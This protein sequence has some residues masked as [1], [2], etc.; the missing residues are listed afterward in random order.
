MADVS[1][2]PFVRKCT[3]RFMSWLI[4]RCCGRRIPDSQ[5]GFRMIHRELAA[6]LFCESDKYDYETEMLFIAASRGFEIGAV[7][8]STV[9]GEEQSKIRP[10]A[11]TVRFFQ[12]LARYRQSEV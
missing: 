4:S 11:D 9:Y 6:H 12:L 1:A 8:V 7:P 10:I 2:M 5:C 3:N